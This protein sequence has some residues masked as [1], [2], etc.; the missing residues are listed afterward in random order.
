[1]SNMFTWDHSENKACLLCH[2]SQ[3]LGHVVAA[4]RSSFDQGRQI[5]RHDPVLNIIANTLSRF[6]KNV[7]E[8]LLSFASPCFVTGDHE[9][10]YIVLVQHKVFTIEE[11]A[12]GFETN[13]EGNSKR[14]RD[15]YK[16]LKAN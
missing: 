11:L 2:S 5:W 4:C 15:I 8:D 12:I 9:R 6:Y 16:S 7:H 14:K 13:M 3:T 10:P 1:M